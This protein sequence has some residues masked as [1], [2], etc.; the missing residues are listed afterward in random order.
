MPRR[1]SA[2]PTWVAAAIGGATRDG[3]MHGPVRAIRIEGHRQPIALEDRAQGR[4]DGDHT[5]PALAQFGVEQALR[6]V[7]DDRDKGE[8]LLGVQRQPAMPTAVQVEQLAETG[9]RLPAPAMATPGL[10]LRHQAGGRQGFLHERIAKA[11]AVLA[12]RQLVKVADIEALIPLAIQREQ[13][14]DVGDGGAL[15]R[16]NLPAPVQEP[17]VA[18]LPQPP[19]NAPDRARTVAQDVG[20]L[21]P[22][23]L[24]INGPENHFLHLHGSLH[25]RARV[26]HGLLPGGH[27]CHATPLE[28]PSHVSMRGGQLTYLQQ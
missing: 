3:R 17:L 16:G 23:E 22:R 21:D 14:L 27:S 8:P 15:G 1:A 24:P 11:H 26:G 4:H 5:F 18:E 12:S 10:V 13:A 7:V 25:P 2:R 9:A 20:G 19:A 6:R 28:W